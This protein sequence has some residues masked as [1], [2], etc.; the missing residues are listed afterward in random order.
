MENPMPEAARL[1]WFGPIPP[2]FIGALIGVSMFALHGIGAIVLTLVGVGIAMKWVYR[3]HAAGGGPVTWSSCAGK[4]REARQ[5][6]YRQNGYQQNGYR[7][8][9]AEPPSSGNHAFD[10][11]R[12]EMLRRLEQ[13]HKDFQSF[14]DRLRHAKDKAE[15]DQF[16]SERRNRPTPPPPP[17]DYQ[18]PQT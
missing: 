12:R 1:P 18:P 7:Q 16:M 6:G 8:N 4:W 2:L 5:N 3:W 14:L 17:A 9:G 10:E 13:D 11:Y 15:F